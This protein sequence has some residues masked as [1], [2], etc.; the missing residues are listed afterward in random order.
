MPAALM[1]KDLPTV[2]LGWA[3]PTKKCR[4]NCQQNQLARPCLTINKLS[5]ADFQTEPMNKAVFAS[6]GS[7]IQYY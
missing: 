2:P 3:L 4:L 7:V 6:Q 5:W 1:G